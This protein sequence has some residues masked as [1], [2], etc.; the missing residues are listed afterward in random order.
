MVGIFIL[1][2]TEKRIIEKVINHPNLKQG[3][4]MI[5]H[6]YFTKKKLIIEL[7]AT[8][9]KLYDEK[10]TPELKNIGESIMLAYKLTGYNHPDML[11][12]NLVIFNRRGK[13]LYTV[14]SSCW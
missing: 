2:M 12:V 7:K 10:T 13:K 14:T 4:E 6:I 5:D 8:T 9:N 3:Y 1:Y 11:A